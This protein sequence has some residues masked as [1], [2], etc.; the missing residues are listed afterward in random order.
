VGDP[1]LPFVE[2]E[3]GGFFE[4]STAKSFDLIHGAI[5]SNAFFHIKTDEAITLGRLVVKGQKSFTSLRGNH[6]G[7]EVKITH[8][9]HK[10]NGSCF[11]SNEGIRLETKDYTS[12]GGEIL[13]MDKDLELLTTGNCYPVGDLIEVWKGNAKVTANF[14]C[15]HRYNVIRKGDDIC[16]PYWVDYA[17]PGTEPSRLCVNG[18]IY[19]NVNKG[20]S[21]SSSIL[22]SGMIVG[23][24]MI[25]PMAYHFYFQSAIPYSLQTPYYILHPARCTA[26]SRRGWSNDNMV[27]MTQE[28]SIDYY[29]TGTPP[30][31]PENHISYTPLTHIEGA[32]G[33]AFT[34]TRQARVHGR[35]VGSKL[36]LGFE[37]DLIVQTVGTPGPVIP[38]QP[39]MDLG[40]LC[41]PSRLV[42]VDTT[43]KASS[44]LVPTVPLR[45]PLDQEL[46]G[47]ERL[48]LGPRGSEKLRFALPSFLEGRALLEA[49]QQNIGYVPLT[50]E[51]PDY[52][53]L[54]LQLRQNGADVMKILRPFLETPELLGL[55]SLASSDALISASQGLLQGLPLADTQA[56]AQKLKYPLIFYTPH[57]VNDERV[58]RPHL[59]TPFSYDNP[60][61]RACIAQLWAKELYLLGK[62]GSHLHLDKSRLVADQGKIVTGLL[63]LEEEIAHDGDHYL[64]CLGKTI[65][66]DTW[67]IHADNVISKL[68]SIDVKHLWLDVLNQYYSSGVTKA[69]TLVMDVK[70][71]TLDREQRE[72]TVTYTVETTTKTKNSFGH[73]KKKSH[74]ESHT[75][76]LKESYPAHLSGLLAFE[77]FISAQ[78]DATALFPER[79]EGREMESLRIY[80]GGVKTGPEGWRHKVKGEIEVRSKEE[81]SLAPFAIR[82]KGHSKQGMQLVHSPQQPFIEV[83]QK[84]LSLTAQMI[85]L[86]GAVLKVPQGK[87]LLEALQELWIESAKVIEHLAPSYYQAKGKIHEVG[88]WQE[89]FSSSLIEALGVTLKAPKIKGH[90]P[91]ASCSIQ[92]DTLSNTLTHP[93]SQQELYDI[94][95]G[96]VSKGNAGFAMVAALAVGL[97]S[98]GTATP[99][100]MAA[101][102]GELGGTIAS[103]MVASIT[104]QTASSLVMHQGNLKQVGRDLTSKGMAVDLFATLVTPGSGGSLTF[105]QQAKKQVIRASIRAGLNVAILGEKPKHALKEA[106]KY[107]AVN[108]VAAYTAGKIG[109]AYKSGYGP[110]DPVSHKLLHGGIGA[111]TG[112]LMDLKGDSLR[113]AASGA[114]GAIVAET[115]A[116]VLTRQPHE[117]LIDMMREAKAEGKELTKEQYLKAY[118]DEVHRNMDIGRLCAGIAAVLTRSNVSISLLT[119]NNALE[120]NFAM[121]FPLAAALTP[122][123]LAGIG[124]TGISAY[125]LGQWL[126]NQP[127]AR[128]MLPEGVVW[129]DEGFL[130][131]ESKGEILITPGHENKP[132]ILHTPIADPYS[133]I[134]QTPV[135]DG[136]DTSI[137]LKDKQLL[138][139]QGKDWIKLRGSQG[140][141]NIKDNTIWRKDKLHKDHWDVMN[142]KEQKVKEVDFNGIEIWPNGPK[143]KNKTPQ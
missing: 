135:Y 121:A 13:V 60:E 94:V 6:I 32:Q 4:V 118:Q 126:K 117:A 25:K 10:G 112:A 88:G 110:L 50:P 77:K 74:S 18:N 78:E 14:F 89:K 98:M 119:A 21:W 79:K 97:A 73:S 65:E 102:F 23:Q 1:S 93:I 141:K 22:A 68:G 113:S 16:A 76:I 81:T 19:F 85:H 30:I 37:D 70:H 49:F 87:V 53:S 137:L 114:L 52:L 12:Y 122:E 71:V 41:A 31:E 35:M 115:V 136:P 47:R 109:Q 9:D 127:F 75:V 11:I 131:E 39:L 3:S 107:A 103:A 80:G 48:I 67:E 72:W 36:L 134:L 120:N 140:W 33:I 57:L 29:F 43:G 69:N 143:N 27:K 17:L 133:L 55:P 128:D 84:D 125:Q 129:E 82:Y 15:Q 26:L 106:V 132:L 61:R 45:Y 28:G 56:L 64:P 96:Q 95:V 5:F 83:P 116:D 100:V 91:Q 90:Y 44:L 24:E 40:A 42:Q 142:S 59:Y 101:F 66:G 7:P 62:P 2:I 20:E 99:A 138:P 86:E 51:C 54:H 124:L 38:Y 8:D 46:Q 139:G 63:S 104:S 123:M 34:K 105:L 92:Y 111:L 58:L 108:T 130:P